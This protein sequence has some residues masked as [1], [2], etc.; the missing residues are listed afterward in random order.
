MVVGGFPERRIPGKHGEGAPRPMI[1]RHSQ[2]FSLKLTPT[3]LDCP[4][5]PPASWAAGRRPSGPRRGG[6]PTSHPCP[7]GFSANP[8]W[9]MD[10]QLGWRKTDREV[11][12]QVISFLDLFGFPLTPTKQGSTI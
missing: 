8:K 10:S 7:R 2:C 1:L 11:L 4:P 6:S 3:G 5:N 9:E 12:K